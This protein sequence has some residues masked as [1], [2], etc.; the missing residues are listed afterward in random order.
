MSEKDFEFYRQAITQKIEW[1]DDL[2]QALELAFNSP[3]PDKCKPRALDALIRL[4]DFEVDRATILATLLSDRGLLNTLSED[5][6]KKHFGKSV[7]ALVHGI[8]VINDVKECSELNFNTPEQAEKLRR[9]LMAIVKDVR[10]MLVKLCYRVS[11][12]H[13]LKHCSYEQRQC[14]ARETLDI[15]APL[16]NRLGIGKLKWEMED[17]SFRALEP[18]TF[19]RIATLLEER[20]ADREAFIK[21]FT[22]QLKQL[23][24]S[25]GIH[26]EVSGRVKH[27]VSIWR[28]MQRKK[29]EFHQLFDVRAVRVLVDSVADCYGVLGIVHT[30]WH[31]IPD[32]FDDYIANP[33]DNGYQSLHTAVITENGKVVEVQI[34]THEM[35]SKSEF[36]VAS[37]W[38]YKEGVGLDVRME[39]SIAVMRELLEGS[40]E[41]A[42]DLLSGL[43]TE[44][45]TDRVYVFTPKGNVVDLPYGATPLDFAYSIHSSVGHRC[46]GAKVNGRIV[47]LTYTLQTG[48]QV[49]ILTA[50]EGSPSRDWMNKNSGFLKS[51]SNR[52]KVRN[53]FNHLDFE[54]NVM[55]GKALYEREL[56]KYNFRNVNL[57]DIVAHFKRSEEEQ[58]FADI[59]RG[60]IT[61][62][63]VIGYLQHLESSEDEDPF[64]KI[65]KPESSKPHQKDD[66]VIQG[67]GNLLTQFA[68]CCKPVP[69]DDVIGFITVGSG[70]TVHKRECNNV[71]S[72]PDD[73]KARLIEVEWGSRQ[74]SVFPAEISLTAYDRTGL[75]RDISSVLANEKINL[76]NIQSSTDRKEQTVFSKLN[77]EVSSAEQLILIIDK[78]SQI[79]NVQTVRRTN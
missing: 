40:D 33:K 72:L 22:S 35:H 79:T 59:G 48:E 36:G 69:G 67:V 17:L 23:I 38:R 3:S 62:P 31:S 47:N 29:L 75:L 10:V 8:R 73:K 1:D 43:S 51:S 11:R 12:M 37:H 39:K 60:L 2:H 78:L 57:S 56:G 42:S 34:R 63:Q 54:Q 74:G 76:L 28:K 13:L 27:I 6:I 68:K 19:K 65:K 9:L 15:Y 52:A 30:N 26:G 66:I 45:S 55:D 50:K 64:K 49:E 21:Q 25:Q 77:V 61:T 16:A 58:F 5:E 18:L 46:R 24:S 70:V 4:L 44:L 41:N 20:R 32:E 14:I 71:L 53:W 7:A